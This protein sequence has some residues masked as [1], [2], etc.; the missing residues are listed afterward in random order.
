MLKSRFIEDLFLDFLDLVNQRKLKLS[1][2]DWSAAQS[3]GHIISSNNQLTKNQANFMVKILQKYRNLAVEENFNYD[4]L[5]VEPEWKNSFRVLDLSKRFYVEKDE[6]GE[7]WVC[8]KFPFSLKDPLE[9]AIS[10]NS[11]E[12]PTSIWDN[13]N[14]VRRLRLYN[15]NLI[16]LYEFGLKYG[17][18]FDETFMSAMAEIEEI[19]ENS[20][21]ISPYCDVVDNTVQLFNASNETLECFESLRSGNTNKDLLTAKSMAFF[22]QKKPKNMVE[23]ICSSQNNYFHIKNFENFFDIHN[24]CDSTTAVI[25]GKSED[26]LEWIKTFVH[27]AKISGVSNE[28][29]K[30]CFRLEKAEDKGFNQWIKDHGYGGKVAGGKILIFQNKPPKWLFTDNIDVKIIVTNSLYPVPSAVTQSWMNNHN[31]VCF[32]GEI[33]A[34]QI[35]DKKIVEL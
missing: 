19:W 20:E 16:Q 31:C 21:K 26:D 28:E 30:V 6:E 27:Q 4:H 7:V 23:K 1:N 9:K 17:F 15:Y 14:K 29:I 5:L 10:A 22:Y 2:Q 34:S 25:T 35:K 13:D 33:K 11:K 32:L 12:Y 24:S 3:F 18:E 8:A